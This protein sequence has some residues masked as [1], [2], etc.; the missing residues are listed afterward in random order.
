[1]MRV[2]VF[3]A[4][5]GSSLCACQAFTGTGDLE[6]KQAGAGA[7]AS[8]AGGAGGEGGTS[9][10]A[11]GGGQGGDPSTSVGS[12][13]TGS[14]TAS[15]GSGAMC[16][17]CK[18]Y[19]ERMNTDPSTPFCANSQAAHDSLVNCLCRNAAGFDCTGMADTCATFCSGTPWNPGCNQCAQDLCGDAWTLCQM[20]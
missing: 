4:I 15:S 13:M 10:S 9:T 3:L 16:I 19:F 11:G 12:A 5:L 6:V 17:T 2:L 14:Q 18:Q 1:M 8:A 20:K 7:G